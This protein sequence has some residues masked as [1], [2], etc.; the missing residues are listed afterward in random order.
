MKFECTKVSFAAWL[1]AIGALGLAADVTS[2]VGWTALVGLAL[3]PP[4]FM[5]RFW[6][7]APQSMSESIREAR[8]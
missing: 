1:L 4:V 8:R 5:L 2:V 6:N 3:L 7:G